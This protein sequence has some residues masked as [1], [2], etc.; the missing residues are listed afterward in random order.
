MAEDAAASDG[1][2][3]QSGELEEVEAGAEAEAGDDVPLKS[4]SPTHV[5]EV[6]RQSKERNL[7]ARLLLLKVWLID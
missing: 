3:Y 4:Q 6:L 2:H 1:P 5:I 7:E